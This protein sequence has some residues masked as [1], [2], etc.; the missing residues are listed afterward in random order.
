MKKL[1]ALFISAILLLSLAA[2]GSPATNKLT[3]R[4]TPETTTAAPPVSETS[5]EASPAAEGR[6]E[7]LR[8]IGRPLGEIRNEHPGGE[9]LSLVLPGFAGECFGDPAAGYTYYFF[10]TQYLDIGEIGA[11]FRDGLPCA[12]IAST[13]GVLFPEAADGM[14]L[15]A[16][17]QA[18]AATECA[19]LDYPWNDYIR[20]QWNGLEAWVGPT[21]KDAETIRLGDPVLLSDRQ[22][23]IDNMQLTDD[24]ASE[25]LHRKFQ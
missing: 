17:A 8:E 6:E 25:N 11:E 10:G 16:F 18:I 13:I 12:G 24:W 22:I 20:F 2:C 7:L 15:E 23:E 9:F 19:N 5:K 21:P 3:T 4:P 14:G 1:L